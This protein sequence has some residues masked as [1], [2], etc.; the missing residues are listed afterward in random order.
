[1]G[2]LAL[3]FGIIGGLCAVLGIITA[4][5]VMPTLGGEYTWTFWFGLSV[6]LLLGSVASAVGR[7]GI[8]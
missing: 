7:G 8:E 6:I 3:I 1:M 2:M 4:A 5:G